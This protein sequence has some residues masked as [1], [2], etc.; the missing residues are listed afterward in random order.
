MLDDVRSLSHLSLCPV[1]DSVAL[2][3]PSRVVELVLIVVLFFVVSL[4]GRFVT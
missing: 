2:L 4:M 1:V 3:I